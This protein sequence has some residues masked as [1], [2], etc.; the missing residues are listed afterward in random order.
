[1]QST[2]YVTHDL[3]LEALTNTC[4]CTNVILVVSLSAY[5][6]Q[7]TSPEG[8]IHSNCVMAAPLGYDLTNLLSNDIFFLSPTAVWTRC[9]PLQRLL[10]VCL[11]QTLLLNRKQ[12]KSSGS[13]RPV[14]C[15]AACVLHL[16][17]QQRTS[18]VRLQFIPPYSLK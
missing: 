14:L 2:I 9:S 15:V 4:I 6:Q 5:V 13:A 3:M 18:H 8:D 16:A 7:G 11:G 1:M 10:Y 12:S 17:G